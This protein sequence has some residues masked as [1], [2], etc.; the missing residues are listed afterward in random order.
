MGSEEG[1]VEAFPLSHPNESNNFSAVNLYLDEVGQLKNLPR[2]VRAVQLAATC[3]YDNVPL[4]GDMYVGRVRRYHGM[5][6]QNMDFTIDELASYA[7]W[8]SNI[9]KENYDAGIAR[10]AVK[11]ST[12]DDDSPKTYEDATKGYK[13]TETNDNIDITF[14]LP[15][16]LTSKDLKVLFKSKSVEIVKKSDPSSS[17][18]RISLLRGISIDDSTWTGNKS[19]IEISLEKSS[20]GLWNRLEAE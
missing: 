8:L 16:G 7:K 12:D 1:A 5:A 13:W 3:G 10:N 18:L 6:V 19:D 17:L 15:D 20:S 9:K 2:N 14:K 11:L 4:V